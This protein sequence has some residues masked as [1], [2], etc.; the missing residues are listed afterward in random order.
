MYALHE[1]AV[2]RRK[3]ANLAWNW[4]VGMI[5]PRLAPSASCP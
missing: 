5:S 3:A 4:N 2:C 1:Q